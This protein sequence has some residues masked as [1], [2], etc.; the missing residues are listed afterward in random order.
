MDIDESVADELPVGERVQRLAEL[1]AAAAHE[2]AW[3]GS[4]AKPRWILAADTLVSLNDRVFAKAEDRAEAGAMLS[5][6]AGTTHQVYSGLALI[7]GVSGAVNSIASCT[8]VRF[9][10]LSTKEIEAYLDSGEWR[11][12]A[13]AYRIQERAAFFVERIEGSFSGVV[14]LPLREFYVIL[15]QAAYP[16]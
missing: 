14:G 6:L 10:P 2:R 9:A 16:L 13:G 8:D 1:K 4:G 3:T 11:G 15:G 5:A 7:D 12:V